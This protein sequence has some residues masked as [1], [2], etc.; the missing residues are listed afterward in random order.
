[1]IMLLVAGMLMVQGCATIA[2]GTTKGIHIGS[3]PQGVDFQIDTVSQFDTDAVGTYVAAGTTPQYVRITRG[4]GFFR[5]YIVT[6]TDDN[7]ETKTVPIR[8]GVNGWLFGNILIGGIPGIIIDTVT[9]ASS[10]PHNVHVYLNRKRTA[11]N[12]K[13]QIKSIYPLPKKR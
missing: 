13:K 2:S 1:M 7:Y 5:R 11:V 9:G 10:D 6:F 4:A 8:S 12:Y 3:R